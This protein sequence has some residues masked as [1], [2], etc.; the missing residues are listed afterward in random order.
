MDLDSLYVVGYGD[1]AFAGNYD[2]SSQLG[3]TILLKDKH[4]NAALIHYGSW[5]YHRV[6]RSVI[7]AEIY[8]V[9]HC[10]DYISA[11]RNDLS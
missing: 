2:L 10:L 7:G 11:L 8:A 3:F 4:D 5:K 1:G 9:S 6:V